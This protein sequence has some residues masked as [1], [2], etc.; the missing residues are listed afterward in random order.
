MRTE[1]GMETFVGQTSN[2]SRSQRVS[3]FVK[4]R[5]IV[6][7]GE[8]VDH[9]GG[10]PIHLGVGPLKQVSCTI[11]GGIEPGKLQL[12]VLAE[13]RLQ[14]CLRTSTTGR[15]K[16]NVNAT[17]D[18]LQKNPSLFGGSIRSLPSVRSLLFHDLW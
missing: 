4:V 18:G 13:H 3:C 5:R 10:Q 7:R 14:R 6:V 15:V 8:P 9:S 2:G 17:R 12:G 1:A 11:P 16:Q